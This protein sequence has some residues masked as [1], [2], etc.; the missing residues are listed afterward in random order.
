MK[1]FKAILIGVR[2]ISNFVKWLLFMVL[3]SK[4][5]IECIPN[6]LSSNYHQN[7]YRNRSLNT[8]VVSY[9]VQ[10]QFCLVILT[11]NTLMSLVTYHSNSYSIDS[12]SLDC[13]LDRLV[14]NKL[15]QSE[16]INMLINLYCLLFRLTSSLF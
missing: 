3:I 16:S 5:V 6:L 1:T 2:I 10:W 11:F 14:I 12:Y 4:N 8:L 7:Q 13:N 15:Y 9:D